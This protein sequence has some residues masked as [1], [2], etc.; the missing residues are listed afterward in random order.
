MVIFCLRI[1]AI[2]KSASILAQSALLCSKSAAGQ[3][4]GETSPL[5]GK[6]KDYDTH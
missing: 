2:G 4:V 3:G 6:E 5:G 1:N